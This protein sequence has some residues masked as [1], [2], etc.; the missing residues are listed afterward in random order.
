MTSFGRRAAELVKEVAVADDSA[1]PVYNV[2][3]AR[4]ESAC[5][6]CSESAARKGGSKHQFAQRAAVRADAPTRAA[7]R[8]SNCCA[9]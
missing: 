1:L 4:A 9:L 8:R 6:A 3:G 5:A 7:A 2:R